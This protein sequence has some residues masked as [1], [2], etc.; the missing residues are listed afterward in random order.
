MK[1]TPLK[2]GSAKLKKSGNLRFKPKTD[3]QKKEQQDQYEKDIKFYTEEIWNKRPHY[4]QSCNLWLGNK[5]NL[6]YF[7][8]LLPKNKYPELRY[9]P[10]NLYLTCP[11]HHSEKEAGFPHPKH[12][13]AIEEAKRKFL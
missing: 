3:E 4:C 1:K 13:E 10:D 8:H 12:Q 7:D 6:C 5:P 9:E 11:Q 2:K